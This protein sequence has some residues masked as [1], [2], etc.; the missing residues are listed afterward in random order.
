LTTAKEVNYRQ[1]LE[2]G[3]NINNT[4]KYNNNNR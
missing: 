3:Q 2:K 4:V 1:A